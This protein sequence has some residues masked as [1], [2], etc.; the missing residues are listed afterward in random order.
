MVTMVAATGSVA[1][2]K[3]APPVNAT[4]NTATCT[5]LKG[6]AKFSPPISE[7]E[8][9][10]ATE[11]TTIS[12]KL[13]DCTSNLTG[14][15]V[16]DGTVKG[17]FS[18]AITSANGCASLLGSNS[19]SGTLS[20]KWTTT[21]K[22]SS[23]DSVVTVHS[24]QGGVAP[25]GTNAEFQIPGSSPDSGTGSF[26]GTDSGASGSTAAQTKQTV[27]ALGKSCAGKGIKTLTIAPVTGSGA[28]VAAF[29]G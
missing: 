20:T 10:G 29:F 2:A 28:P 26:S 16:K 1:G 13:T 15:T 9:V 23:G 21:P 24:V 19:E 11:V 6:T 14:L 12:A 3:A 18:D 22:L 17:S 25:D 7:T 5:G 27:T 4:N 8:T